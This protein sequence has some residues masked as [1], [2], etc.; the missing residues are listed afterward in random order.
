MSEYKVIGVDQITGRRSS[1]IHTFDNK[2]IAEVFA[3]GRCAQS[4]NKKIYYVEVV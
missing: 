3:C 2:Y 4:N 1:S